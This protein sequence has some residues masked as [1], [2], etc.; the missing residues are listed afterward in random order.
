MST[1]YDLICPHYFLSQSTEFRKNTAT[2]WV[3]DMIQAG[4]DWHYKLFS[5]GGI[6]ESLQGFI[7]LSLRRA[8][9][10]PAH[11]AGG[12]IVPTVSTT[13]SPGSLGSALLFLAWP[14]NGLLDSP[15]EGQ[16]VNEIID[17]SSPALSR[18]YLSAHGLWWSE[19]LLWRMSANKGNR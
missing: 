12:R 18:G 11:S 15:Q 17:R 19:Q 3:A 14:M 1:S 16:G 6:K 7:L 13:K 5:T 8:I 10:S 9:P 2:F 4:V